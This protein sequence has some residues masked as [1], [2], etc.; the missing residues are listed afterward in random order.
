[1]VKIRDFILEQ[2]RTLEVKSDTGLIKYV[3]YCLERDQ[4]NKIKFK[5]NHHHILPQ[6]N[7]L[8][9]SKYKCLKA[10]VW[11][12]VHLLHQDHFIA[13]G[14]LATAVKHE[15]IIFAWQ[16]LRNGK[17]DID[18]LITPELYQA[19]RESFA[20]TMSKKLTG[21]TRSAETCRNI[22]KAK[23]GKTHS[24]LSKRNM[25]IGQQGK[26]HSEETKRKISEYL[27]NMSDEERLSRLAKCKITM[28]NKTD[29]EIAAMK[30]KLSAVHKG[31]KKRRTT[32]PH[33]DKVG[34]I[35]NMKRW[36]FNNCKTLD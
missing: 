18:G 21:T 10:N 24:E 16:R 28:L 25:R 36:H 33:C 8:P 29:E 7:K 23:L 34:A 27:R 15:S 30:N 20:S 12:G 22:S 35:A 3:D 19:L 5:T 17:Y 14:L 2:L 6:A 9:F 4:H 11:N 1:M 26:H 13:H 32:C 31:K